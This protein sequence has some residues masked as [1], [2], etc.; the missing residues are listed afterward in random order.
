MDTFL[1]ATDVT[2]TIPFEDSEGN[3]H[4]ATYAEYRVVDES[5]TEIV[6]NTFI[7]G[8]VSDS[9]EA[10]IGIA[11]AD[12]TLGASAVEGVR[13]VDVFATVNG[14][15]TMIFNKT[16]MLQKEDLLQIGVNSYQTYP[17][18]ELFAKS[19]FNSDGWDAA[20]KN[21]R[22]RAL[23]NAWENLGKLYYWVLTDPYE[24]PT[25]SNSDWAGGLNE[26][27]EAEFLTLDAE[28]IKAVRRAQVIEADDILG[29]NPVED[30]RSE[31]LMS[32]TVGESSQMYRPGKPLL[33]PVSRKALEA[34]SGWISF[35][36][37]I[38][39]G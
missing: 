18:A 30:I 7:P 2:I 13:S 3:V 29:G 17:Q 11:A 6:A 23:I 32:K 35:S 39:R 4:S 1:D 34:L 37:R 19:I 36:K 12:N 8:F 9:K 24:R 28:F 20:T 38:G 31:G 22:V 26:L 5:G 33:L 21:Q 10:V 15:N 27:T 25:I 14:E 16:Y